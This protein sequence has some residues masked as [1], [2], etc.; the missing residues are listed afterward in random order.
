MWATQLT[1]GDEQHLK[2]RRRY[3]A[4]FHAASGF[5]H[6]YLQVVRIRQPHGP[7]RININ[8]S[9]QKNLLRIAESPTRIDLVAA[10]IQTWNGAEYRLERRQRANWTPGGTWTNG[11]TA[12]FDDSYAG[13][14][15]QHHS[16]RRGHHRRHYCQR[17]RRLF[18]RRQ[19]NRR[20][21]R[22]SKE[23]HGSFYALPARNTFT[24]ATNH[25]RHV[26]HQFRQLARYGACI[27]CR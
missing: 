25:R 12:R 8:G 9:L 3:R 6:G 22:S 10:L 23:R 7:G 18:D 26:G 11:S 27:V 13:S 20:T 16:R 2:H 5:Q 17:K 1:Y 19:W 24:G 4:Q 21:G 15:S 14:E